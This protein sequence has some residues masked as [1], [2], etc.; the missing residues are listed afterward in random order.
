MRTRWRSNSSSSASSDGSAKASDEGIIEPFSFVMNDMEW[1][2]VTIDSEDN[3]RKREQFENKRKA[4]YNEWQ[5]IHA[6]RA[7]VDDD[8]DEDES[9]DDDDS[10]SAAPAP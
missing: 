8:D 9:D 1:L 4:H 6:L 5:A 3:R 7:R 10:A 2:T